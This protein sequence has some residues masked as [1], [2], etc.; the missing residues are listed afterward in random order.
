MSQAIIV[1]VHE[2]SGEFCGS[3]SK[4]PPSFFLLP[5]IKEFYYNALFYALFC[6]NV[7]HQFTALFNLHPSHFRFNSLWLVLFSFFLKGIF[8]I[9]THFFRNTTRPQNKGFAPIFP[10]E[11]PFHVKWFNGR[12]YLFIPQ[13][14]I[15]SLQFTFFHLFSNGMPNLFSLFLFIII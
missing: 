8:F 11:F 10:Y 15:L 5:T 2:H 12:L 7:P 3:P 9:Y 4:L 6:V 13:I 14:L 1:L